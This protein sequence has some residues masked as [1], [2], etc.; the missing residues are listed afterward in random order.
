MIAPSVVGIA[1]RLRLAGCVA[2]EEEAIELITAASGV[3]DRLEQMVRER[4]GGAPLAWVTGSTEF[5]GLRVGV[6]RGV[7]VPRWQT[8]NVA[9]A[10]SAALPDRGFAVELCCGTG[11]I[12]MVLQRDHPDARV[13]AVDIDPIAVTCAREN[14]IEAF[15]ADVA[16]LRAQPARTGLIGLADVVVAV[17]PYVPDALVDG[18]LAGLAATHEPRASLAGGTDGLDV[19]RLVIDAATR[20]LRPG[21]AVVVEA[22]GPQLEPVLRLLARKDFAADAVIVDGEGD[23]CG[24][25]GRLRPRGRIG[26]PGRDARPRDVGIP[27]ID[28]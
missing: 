12:S 2:A 25:A 18:D 13:V 5:C 4:V 8:E 27:A 24:V 6:D 20:L 15:V 28:L 7:Y 22:G 16:E 26:L 17:A 23:P 19:V 1:H 9:R 21:G 10:A 14:G 3:D 11:A